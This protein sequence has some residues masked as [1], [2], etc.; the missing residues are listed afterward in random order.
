MTEFRTTATHDGRAVPM[1]H[2][3]AAKCDAGEL[4]AL[5]GA[6]LE[7][8][9]ISEISRVGY[10]VD[11]TDYR[12]RVAADA[13]ASAAPSEDAIRVAKYE[14][15][16]EAIAVCNGIGVKTIAEYLKAEQTKYAP[17]PV[18]A[19]PVALSSWGGVFGQ[20][21]PDEFTHWAPSGTPFKSNEHYWRTQGRFTPADGALVL[22]VL[23]GAERAK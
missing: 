22:A 13:R 11:V 4:I 9:T 2:V 17:R 15:L 3:N 1:P 10:N 23:D 18:Y 6:Y 5:R 7:R 8:P 14:A 19:A 12:D 16:E 20:T 21:G